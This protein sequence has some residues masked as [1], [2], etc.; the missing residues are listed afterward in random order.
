ML[1]LNRIHLPIQETSTQKTPI[2]L[3]DG[4]NALNISCCNI[5]LEQMLENP[6]MKFAVLGVLQMR[7][8]PDCQVYI[9][10]S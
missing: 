3:E 4:L 9:P 7:I 6:N 8:N 5:C 1:K 10:C 2:F